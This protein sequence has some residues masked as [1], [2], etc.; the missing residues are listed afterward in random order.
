MLIVLCLEVTLLS[1]GLIM[2]LFWNTAAG[3]SQTH[4]VA[5]TGSGWFMQDTVTESS[6]DTPGW[7]QTSLWGFRATV[8]TCKIR[9]AAKYQTHPGAV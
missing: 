9:L 7:H 6:R 5:S 4:I 8:Q 1:R 3:F 2:C